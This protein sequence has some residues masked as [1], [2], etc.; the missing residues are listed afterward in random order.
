MCIR[1]SCRI[2]SSAFAIFSSM[3]V[4]SKI[5]FLISGIRK[6]GSPFRDFLLGGATARVAVIPLY[7]PLVLLL[8]KIVGL[9]DSRFFRKMLLHP[10]VR[11]NTTWLGC[12]PLQVQEVYCLRLVFDTLEEQVIL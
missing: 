1:D 11:Q 3:S 9:F 8:C 2:S 10:A 12:S 4:M 5:S 6:A 7:V